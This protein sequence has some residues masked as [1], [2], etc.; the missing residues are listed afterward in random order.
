[1]V[2]KDAVDIVSPMSFHIADPA[3]TT[4]Q[5]LYGGLLLDANSPTI[6]KALRGLTLDPAVLGALEV[7]DTVLEAGLYDNITTRYAAQ[8]ITRPATANGMEGRSSGYPSQRLYTNDPAV[9]RTQ[10]RAVARAIVKVQEQLRAHAHQ[11]L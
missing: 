10:W 6:V 1:M 4:A 2:L 3:N 11:E 8:R 7:P 5:S 9:L